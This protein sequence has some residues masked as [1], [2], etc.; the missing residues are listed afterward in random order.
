MPAGYWALAP[1]SKGELGPLIDVR[2]AA[3]YDEA[4]RQ[5]GLFGASVHTATGESFR[6][7]F[8]QIFLGLKFW[9]AAIPSAPSGQHLQSGVIETLLDDLYAKVSRPLTAQVAIVFD[10][11]HLPRSGVSTA[12]RRYPQNTWRNNFQLQKGVGC[13]APYP[14][15]ED[16]AFLAMP[17]ARCPHLNATTPGTLAGA[18]CALAPR[19]PHY[20]GEEHQKWM[21]IDPSGTG[22]ASVDL[23]QRANYSPWV[24]PAGMRIPVLPLVVSLYH[25]SDPGLPASGRAGTVDLNSFATDFHFTPDELT[26]YFDDDPANSYNAAVMAAGTGAA[27]VR[28]AGGT[29]TTPP[30]IA[31]V[32]RAARPMP[33]PRLVGTTVAPPVTTPWWDAEQVV[34]KYLGSAGWEAHVVSRQQLGYDILAKEGAQTLFVEVKSSSGYC[35]PSLTQREWEQA[36]I[37]GPAYVLAVL[38]HFATSGPNTIFWIPDPARRC[39]GNRRSAVFYSIPRS[40]WNGATIPRL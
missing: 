15:I 18:T 12:G 26:A 25:D 31:V 11:A 38:E 40:S 24:A 34:A 16:P 17:R 7:R 9:E 29:T 2:A 23:L 37:H 22:F 19:S 21:K 6:G 30:R 14:E 32:G 33:P 8:V 27:Y 13:Y 5:L 39:V 1:F 3:V 36:S 20:R 28:F 35:T 10:A 4:L